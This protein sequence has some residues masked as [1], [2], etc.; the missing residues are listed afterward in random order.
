MNIAPLNQIHNSNYF[1]TN[2]TIYN[3]EKQ[4][5]TFAKYKNKALFFIQHL[6]HEMLAD[7]VFV[8]TPYKVMNI[9]SITLY[10]IMPRL[11]SAE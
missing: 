6:E 5:L 8:I 9:R 4:K 10:G 2:I 11:L 3:K 7:S 1:A